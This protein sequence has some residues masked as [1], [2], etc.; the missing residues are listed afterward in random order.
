MRGGITLLEKVTVLN[1]VYAC[2][3]VFKRGAFVK[4]HVS[5]CIF[6]DTTELLIKCRQKQSLSLYVKTDCFLPKQNNILI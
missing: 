4:W 2:F 1:K 3:S 6:Q 5:L